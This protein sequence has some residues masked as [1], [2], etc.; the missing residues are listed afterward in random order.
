[1]AEGEATVLEEDAFTVSW[2]AAFSCALPAGTLHDT[3]ES[4]IHADL[5]QAV[6]PSLAPTLQ[7][8]DPKAEPKNSTTCSPF[9]GAL[10]A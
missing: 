6:W 3:E 10:W 2:R 1:M 9:A 4:L 5:M 8:E 7:S